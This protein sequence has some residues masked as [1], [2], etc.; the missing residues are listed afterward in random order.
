MCT[1]S[2]QLQPHRW[3]QNVCPEPPRE[4]LDRELDEEREA[5]AEALPGGKP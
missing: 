5:W 3:L 2:A 1:C 4:V